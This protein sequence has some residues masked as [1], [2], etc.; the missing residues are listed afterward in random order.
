[1]EERRLPA[2]SYE[3]I[4]TSEFGY[5]VRTTLGGLQQWYEYRWSGSGRWLLSRHPQQGNHLPHLNLWVL[6]LRTRPP[7]AVYYRINEDLKQVTLLDL[8]VIS[9]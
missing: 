5:L 1:M 8:K 4:E 2:S 7:V 6:M 9:S 3:V